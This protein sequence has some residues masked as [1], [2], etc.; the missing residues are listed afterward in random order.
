MAFEARVYFNP[1]ITQVDNMLQN[2]GFGIAFST[3]M[4]NDTND[5]PDILSIGQNQIFSYGYAYLDLNTQGLRNRI[6]P[7][8]SWNRRN[9]GILADWR[10]TLQNLVLYQNVQGTPDYSLLVINKPF[11]T[12]SIPNYPAISQ[13]NQASQIQFMYNITGE[14]FESGNIKLDNNFKPM[15]FNSMGALQLVFRFT[16][17]NIDPCVFWEGYDYDTP[18]NKIALPALSAQ[19]PNTYSIELNWYLNPFIMMSTEF[20]DTKFT[21]GDAQQGRTMIR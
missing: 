10:Q 20:S 11:F 18:Q 16:S 3:Q 1:F 2:L 14:D 8:A 17:L 6:D 4:V 19:K 21:A 7:Q 5:L 13:Y 9:F 12:S 15:D